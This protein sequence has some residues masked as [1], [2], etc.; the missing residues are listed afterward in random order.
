MNEMNKCIVKY[1]DR[2]VGKS[3]FSHPLSYEIIF[4]SFF[5]FS[6]PITSLL[7]RIPKIKEPPFPHAF[8]NA[9][10]L[11]H[12]LFDF[13]ISKTSFKSYSVVSPINSSNSMIY[14][15]LFDY[16]NLNFIT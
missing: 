1:H 10:T 16:Y 6:N 14:Q 7:S 12:Q 11:L 8:A 2:V 5:A 15:P 4:A 9:L 13:L 3:V